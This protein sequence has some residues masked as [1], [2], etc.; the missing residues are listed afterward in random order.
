MTR[1]LLPLAVFLSSAASLSVELA[2]V[3]LGAPYVGQSLL[4]WSAAIAS[5]LIGL[6]AGHVLGGIAAGRSTLPIHVYTRLGV[7]WLAAGVT[8][9]I[10]PAAVHA[11]APMLVSEQG[12]DQATVLALAALALP[13]SLAAG[14]VAPLAVRL[15]SMLPDLRMAPMVGAIYA[16][17]AAG[18]VVG[19]AAAGFVL[20][21]TI[22]AAG[23]V[24]TV[25]ALWIA[26]GVCT[27]PWRGL[28]PVRATLGVAVAGIAL[29]SAVLYAGTGPCMQESRYTCV[30][31]YDRP[32]ADGGLLR[33][34]ILDEGVHSASDRDDPQRLHLGYAALADRLAQTALARSPS[35]RALVIGGGGATLPR[36]WASRAHVISIELD[37][38]VRQAANEHMWADGQSR[39]TTLIGDGR[40]V[41]RALPS[42]DTFDVALMDAY[43]TH[44]VPPHLVS[45]EFDAMIARRI[46]TYGVFLSNVIDRADTP[47]LAL[48]IAKTLSAFFPAVDLWVSDSNT[49]GTTNIVV[50]AWKDRDAAHRT[51]AET[52]QAT[53]M[54]AGEAAQTMDVAWRRVDIAAAHRVWPRACAAT[55]TDDWAPVDR[56]LAGRKPC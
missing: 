24:W 55:L 38:V 2:I 49:G 40:A 12:F 42:S 45:R 36:A 26:L 54:D 13:P 34:M 27:L 50:A 53:V 32:L 20:L 19:T 43:R 23:L 6:T 29:T 22:G 5:V 48:S 18:S 41:V 9:S 3:R 37:P 56:L 44:S 46:T 30:R 51:A 14:F 1:W 28:P 35:P 39:L 15:V 10:M 11:T 47:L 33:F 21:E 7:V 16:A 4:P 25:C 52:V 8:A 31:L 17:S